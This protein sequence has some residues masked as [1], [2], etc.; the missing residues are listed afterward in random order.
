[1]SKTYITA[2][3]RRSV[4]ER[5]K[6]CCEYCLQPELF[7]FSPHEID[8]VIAEKHSGTTTEDN[9]ALA[10]KLCNTFKGSDIASVDPENAQITPLYNPRRDRWQ[11]HFQLNDAELIPLTG[12]ARTTIRL[13]HLNRRDRLEERRLWFATG[14]IHLPE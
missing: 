12:K 10:C 3:L 5:A 8:H 14:L 13:L 6:G 9:L 1:M 4:S 2:H 7:S 11:E